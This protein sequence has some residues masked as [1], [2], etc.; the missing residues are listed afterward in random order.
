MEYLLKSYLKIATNHPWSVVMT[1]VALTIA[2]VVWLLVA[3]PLKLDTNF[4]TLLPDEMPC[5]VES[6]R[7]AKLIGSTDH[8]IVAVDSPVPEDNIAV[9]D[10]IAA[11]LA[12]FPEIEYVTT[13]QD[14]A[15]IREHGLYYLE[16][17]DLKQLVSQAKARLDYEKKIKNPFYIALDGEKPPEIG[18]DQIMEKYSQRLRRRGVGQVAEVN[19]TEGETDSL[20]D[21]FQANGGRILSVI[22]Q[23]KKPS[24]DM[25]FARALV[26]KTAAVVESSNP[27]RNP[28]MVVQIAGPYR[29]RF[30]EYQ[31][32]IGDIFSSLGVALG[33][34]V[35]IIVGYFR[36]VRTVAL[37]FVPLLVGILW[38]VGLTALTLGRLNMT[39]ALIFAVLLGLGI[40]FGVHMTVRYLDERARGEALAQ[41]LEFAIIR[42]GKAILTAGFTTA[43]ALSVLMLARFKGFSEFGIIATMG[44]ALCLLVYTA[45]LPAMAVLMERVSKPKPWRKKQPTRPVAGQSARSTRPYVF[46]LVAVGALA[47]MGL[48]SITQIEFEYNF[49]NLRGKNVSATIK[50]GKTLGQGSSPV[51]AVL[52]TKEDAEA[53]T[54]HLEAITDA[55]TEGKNLVKSAFSIFSFVPAEQNIKKPL[56]IELRRLVDQALGLGSLSKETKKKLEDLKGYAHT[57]PVEVN[58]LPSW[59]QDRFKEKDGTVGRIVYIYPRVD[60]WNIAEMEKFYDEYGVIDVPGKGPVRPSASGF[61]F[62]EVIRAVQRDGLLMTGIAVA[63]VFFLLLIDLR[64]LKQAFVVFIPLLVGACWTAGLMAALGIK[65]GLYNMLVLPTMLGIGIDASVHFYHSYREHGPGSLGYVLRTTGSAIVIA[66]ATTAVG[67]VGM[68]VVSHAGLRS[69]GVLAT[70]SITATLAGALVTLPLELAWFEALA[71]RK[72]TREKVS[73]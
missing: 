38:T 39:T 50:Y 10:E 12:D 43:G 19:E 46:G 69:I 53:L 59:I 67:F 29:N 62:V 17:G 11:Q 48:V 40:D 63:V 7:T 73:R 16:V 70:L 9:I 41:A 5:V 49:R 20:K 68:L 65:I 15:Y 2:D 51:V 28:E 45:L 33:L 36:R 22:A 56:I 37:I 32:V 18:F 52:P 8:L 13:K 3:E 35:V 30:R 23:P 27:K 21:R 61:I 57:D 64:S 4:T 34:I 66:A 31:N 58:E 44:I 24:L 14:K 25:D 6:R 26:E 71:R 72:S 47:L 1:I 42:T 60:E 55:D 54:R